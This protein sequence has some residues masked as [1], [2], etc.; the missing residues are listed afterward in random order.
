M[1]LKWMIR[2]HFQVG[3]WDRICFVFADDSCQELDKRSVIH[4]ASAECVWHLVFSTIGYGIFLESGTSFLDRSQGNCF[5]VLQSF[6]EGTSHRMWC[7]RIPACPLAIGIWPCS[8]WPLTCWDPFKEPDPSVWKYQTPKMIRGLWLTSVHQPQCNHETEV[9]MLI[10][11]FE[12]GRGQNSESMR[13]SHLWPA[14][15]LQILRS[16]LLGCNP[17]HVYKE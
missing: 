14:T 7:Y 11:K 5:V 9:V 1:W 3:V 13:D 4:V 16:V 8:P 6:L 12:G 15:P 2:T 10:D 17:N